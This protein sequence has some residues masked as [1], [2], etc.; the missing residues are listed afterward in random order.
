VA[1]HDERPEF[2]AAV[3][4]HVEALTLEIMDL[5]CA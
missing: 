5:A 2:R 4:R 3:E 1:E